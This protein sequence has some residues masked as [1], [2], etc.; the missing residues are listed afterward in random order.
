MIT[1]RRVWA[2]MTVVVLVIAVR[3]GGGGLV[4]K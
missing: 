3:Y 4:G 2:C 1:A